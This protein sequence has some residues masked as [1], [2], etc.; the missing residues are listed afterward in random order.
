MV[1]LP[2]CNFLL[3]KRG[4]SRASRSTERIE[5]VPQVLPQGR[6]ACI[7]QALIQHAGADVDALQVGAEAGTIT[8]GGCE[9][10]FTARKLRQAFAELLIKRSASSRAFLTW[11]RTHWRLGLVYSSRAACGV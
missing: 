3:R 11:T 1:G 4:E 10:K 7:L 8:L 5:D 6:A 2:G 9:F